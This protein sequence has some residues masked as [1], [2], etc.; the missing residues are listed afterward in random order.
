MHLT[1][2]QAQGRVP[3]TILAVHGALDASNYED[4]IAQ[5][6]E[7]YNAGTRY[8]LV[9]MSDISFMSSSGLVALHSIA[10]LLRGEQPPDP[11]LGWQT[12]HAIGHDRDAGAQEHV[13]LLNP[14]AKVKQTL[15]MTGMD[16]FFEIHTDLQTAIASF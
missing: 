7:L 11:E 4:V 5:A 6:Q 2:E 14:Q 9:D 8:L 10:L 3:V 13:K 15:Q 1:S 12:F 16:E